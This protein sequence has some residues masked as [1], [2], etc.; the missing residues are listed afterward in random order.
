MAIIQPYVDDYTYNGGVYNW[1]PQNG[2]DICTCE[3]NPGDCVVLTPIPQS[4]NQLALLL[5]AA[6]TTTTS[7]TTTSTITTTTPTTTTT[8]TP[9]TTST[10]TTTPTTTTTTTEAP[11]NIFLK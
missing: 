8:T 1:V 6:T 5:A 3:S 10:T 11:A 2:M 4:D 7:T 9:T